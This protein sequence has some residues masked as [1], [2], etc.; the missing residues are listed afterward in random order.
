MESDLG[1]WVVINEPSRPR[2]ATDDSGRSA[3][4]A[5]RDGEDLPTISRLVRLEK[6]KFWGL[7]P[8]SESR[9][10]AVAA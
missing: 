8:Y 4:Q 2:L 1:D 9:S 6:D 3:L 5:A 10:L 7:Y